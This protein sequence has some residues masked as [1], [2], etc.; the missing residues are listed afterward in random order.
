MSDG[1]VPVSMLQATWFCTDAVQSRNKNKECM[2]NNQQ[3]DL[4]NQQFPSTSK[5]CCISGILGFELRV[6]WQVFSI[7]ELC[8]LRKAQCRF[9]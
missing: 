7:E 6:K 1:E 4:N 2:Y 3:W 5:P 8:V 9:P